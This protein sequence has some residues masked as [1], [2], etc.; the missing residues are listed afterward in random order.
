[1]TDLAFVFF[2]SMVAR[3]ASISDFRKLIS[4]GTDLVFNKC[5]KVNQD[6]MI[7]IK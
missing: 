4:I 2:S 6:A 7:F 1:M 3:T 5:P